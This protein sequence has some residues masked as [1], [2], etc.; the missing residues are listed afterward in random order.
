MKTQGTVPSEEKVLRAESDTTETVV[1]ETGCGAI[2]GLAS[3]C[4]RFFLG[5]PYA[6]AERFCYAKP[7]EHWDGILD[8][9]KPGKSCPQNRAWH[10]HL[11]NPT[12]LFYKKEFREGIAFE[13]DE[14]CLNLNIFTPTSQEGCPVM[15]FIHGGGFDSGMNSES[16][17]DGSGLAGRGI[18]T[19]FINYRVGPLGYLTHESIRQETGRDGNFGL[20]DQLLAIRWVKAHIADFGGDPDRITLAGQSAGAISIQYLCLNPDHAGLFERAMMMSGAG[21][22]PKFALPRKADDTH[23]YW[24]DYMKEA[25]CKT[26]DELRTADL[27]TLFDA[28]EA[29]KARRKDTLYNTMPV[30]DGKL[31][32]EP[33]DAMM[34]HPLPL[35]YL[36]GYTN[37]DMYAPLMAFIGNRFGKKTGAYLYYFDIDAPGDDNRAFHSCDLRY[38]FETLHK[39]WRPYGKRDYEASGQL[40]Q[41]VANF[42]RS[43]NPNGAGL[44]LWQAA[45]PEKGAKVLHI[46]PLKTAMGRAGFGKMLVNFI[47]RGDPKA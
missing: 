41:Y 22:F 40:A 34:S 15:I 32:P 38:V 42:V 1:L 46:S 12:R 35:S 2:R 7:V 9:V 17:F 45:G 18:V 36:I 20:D 5:V 3:G 37:A 29:L 14:D 16:P 27:D 39:S 44:P 26:L 11:E 43:G 23:E 24:L 33:I 21:L 19:V 30:V 25:G 28:V 47:R 10:E 6:K 4:C 13:Y 31:I 8:A